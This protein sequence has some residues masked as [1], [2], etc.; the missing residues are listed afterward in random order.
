M[1]VTYE[2][3]LLECRFNTDFYREANSSKLFIHPI[4][5]NTLGRRYFFEAT[6]IRKTLCKE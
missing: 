5:I 1:I 6:P 4:C 3:K 2:L